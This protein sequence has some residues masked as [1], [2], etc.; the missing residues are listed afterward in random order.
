MIVPFATCRTSVCQPLR[1]R[2]AVR[3]GVVQSTIEPDCSFPRGVP[4]ALRVAP[5]AV[6]EVLEVDLAVVRVERPAER[7][8]LVE[9]LDGLV[10]RRAGDRRVPEADVRR[11]RALAELP[12]LADL[13]LRRPRVGPVR[14]RGHAQAP[15]PDGHVRAP[16]AAPGTPGHPGF[17][18]TTQP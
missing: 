2:F 16:P 7:A 14:G 5:A 3:R 6:R 4:D 10:A 13:R 17:V 9:A 12:L 8:D 11:V 18:R 1:L 15:V